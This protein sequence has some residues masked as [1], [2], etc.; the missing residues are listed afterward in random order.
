MARALALLDHNGRNHNFVSIPQQASVG[1]L[2][3][4]EK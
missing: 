2:P 3:F 1:P 4:A